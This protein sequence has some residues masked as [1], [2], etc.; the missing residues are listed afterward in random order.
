MSASTTSLDLPVL[1]RALAL[2]CMVDGHRRPQAV[3]QV[4]L[5]V[6]NALEL[7][8]P[9]TALTD[10]QGRGM[11]GDT[12]DGWSPTLSVWALGRRTQR[13]G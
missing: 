9:L 1:S 2:L 11:D 5:C 6:T 7:S 10:S 3:S 8:G 13:L 4:L 12:G